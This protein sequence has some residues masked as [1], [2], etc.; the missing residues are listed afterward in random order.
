MK[1][2]LIIIVAVVLLGMAGFFIFRKAPE[3]KNVP[4]KNGTILIFG[5]SLA[6][7]VG[8]TAGNDL[9]SRLAA[10]LG[11]TVLN[12]G[13]SGDTT[14]DGLERM[15]VAAN[16]DPG[17]VII[18]LGGND[19]LRKIPQTETFQNLEKIVT[20]FQSNGAVVALVGVRSGLIGGGRDADFEAVAKRAG[21][22]YVPDILRDVFGKPKYMS[23]PI[24]PNDAGY[25]VIE[26]RLTPI[27]SDLFGK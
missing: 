15:A 5:D 21:A 7:G 12:Y 1:R 22:V 19:V 3:I 26:E 6:E 2:T 13:K 17:V 27:V 20:Y 10:Q 23:D 25:A 8:A 16:E 9:S 18:I 4:P 11:K 24:H 14:R